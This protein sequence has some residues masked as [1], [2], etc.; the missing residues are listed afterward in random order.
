MNF[1]PNSYRCYVIFKVIHPACISS[2]FSVLDKPEAIELVV[3]MYKKG[4]K[5]FNMGIKWSATPI[6]ND[7]Y[8]NISNLLY[9]ISEFITLDIDYV[10]NL[11]SEF[12]YTMEKPLLSPVLPFSIH[13]YNLINLAFMLPIHTSTNYER[14]ISTLD[15]IVRFMLKKGLNL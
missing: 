1:I 10:I 2:I 5:Y 9:F 14:D 7:G 15:S 3:T 11:V 6:N 4:L 8:D 12:N 13:N